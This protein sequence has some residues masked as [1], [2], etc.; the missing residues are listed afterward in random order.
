M[1]A[2]PTII[3]APGAVDENDVLPVA[4]ILTVDDY[5]PSLYAHARLL[6]G[7][8]FEVVEATTGRSA[9]E[10]AQRERPDLVL[11]DVHLPDIHGFEVC[12]RLK[13]HRLTKDIPV[14]HIT[15]TSRGDRFQ[16]ESIAAGAAAFLQEPID[17]Q[18]L[19]RL[20]GQLLERGRK[21][22]PSTPKRPSGAS[23]PRRA[24]RK[25]KPRKARAR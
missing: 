16:R 4:S 11:L 3:D 13:S 5:R 23:T 9:L 22:R 25:A 6:R 18:L 24:S 1:D 21:R 19:L 14:V 17:P 15:S 20:V 12:E 8:G 10:I 2:A 7:A